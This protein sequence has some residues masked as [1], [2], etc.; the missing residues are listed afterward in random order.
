MRRRFV[1]LLVGTILVALGVQF[2]GQVAQG[3]PNGPRPGTHRISVVCP[4]TKPAPLG[5]STSP[6]PVVTKANDLQVT[7]PPLVFVT[8]ESGVLRVSTN[9]G[10][11]PATTDEF[12]LIRRNSAGHAPAGMVKAVLRS[13]R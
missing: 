9:T 13:C 8:V 5:A 7:V 2:G 11:P 12:Y 4:A 6:S 3:T 10:R 1:E